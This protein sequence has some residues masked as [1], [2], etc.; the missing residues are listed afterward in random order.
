MKISQKNKLIEWIRK[1]TWNELKLVVQL[2]EEEM[3]N[4]GPKIYHNDAKALGRYFEDTFNK[5]HP[6][7]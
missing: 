7:H 6:G 2:C 5:H 3:E 1:R 4:K